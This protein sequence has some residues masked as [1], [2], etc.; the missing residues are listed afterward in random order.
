MVHNF[1]GFVN[2]H[3]YGYTQNMKSKK[4]RRGRLSRDDWIG[5]ALEAL[6]TDGLGAVAVEPLARRLGVTKGSFYWH[7]ENLD[8]LVGAALERWAVSDTAEV[9]AALERIDD[10]RDRLAQLMSPPQGADKSTRID[11]ALL[12]AAGDP[13]IFP[14]LRKHHR[15]WLDFAEKTYSHMGLQ[16]AEAKRWALLA[17]GAYLG[18]TEL[19]YTNPETV[20]AKKE[21]DA[22]L[23]FGRTI[24]IPPD[25]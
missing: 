21:L 25:S 6:S 5:A 16:Q 14:W 10:P 4:K 20:P 2:T 13:R 11:I 19:R 22:Y 7:F 8:A 1:R 23:A 17:Y 3:P 24:L 9:L 15:L 18:L 12:S